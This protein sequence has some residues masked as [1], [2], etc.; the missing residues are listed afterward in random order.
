MKNKFQRNKMKSKLILV[1][2][3][4]LFGVSIGYAILSTPLTIS[5][6]SKIDS[7]TWDIHW[8][9]VVVSEESTATVTQRAKIDTTDNTKA[10]FNITFNQPGDFYE[11]TIDAVNVGTI[12]GM[13]ETISNKI[14][15]GNSTTETT[16]PSYL[17]YTVRYRDGVEVEP[18]HLLKAGQTERYKIRVEYKKDIDESQL[19]TTSQTLR[20][21]C[22]INYVQSDATAITRTKNNTIYA[23]NDLVSRGESISNLGT[24]SMNYQDIITESGHNFFLRHE[25]TASD[26]IDNSSV[27]FVLNGNPYYLTGGDGGASFSI[28]KATLLEA[29]GSNNCNVETNYI[30]CTVSGLD[31]DADDEGIVSASDST[32]MCTV[33]ANASSQCMN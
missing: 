17:I 12:D 18:N 20:F 15:E 11:F 7:V 5:G 32:H 26:L 13:I 16:L 27:G 31:A 25:I 28:N 2:G 4:L 33:Y 1:L 10:T 29:F 9:N 14:Y 3:I 23:F 21:E 19:P 24:T 22:N 8:D 30:Y 6:T